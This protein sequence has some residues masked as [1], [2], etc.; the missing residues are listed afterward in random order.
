MS[1][2]SPSSTLGATKSMMQHDAIGPLFRKRCTSDHE[3]PPSAVL[4]CGA[5]AL[6][7][8]AQILVRSVFPAAEIAGTDADD[9]WRR[10]SATNVQWCG[11]ATR[12]ASRLH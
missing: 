6:A 1:I 8:D 9:E 5:E 3:R 10:H 12:R 11:A 7:P 2:A 4:P